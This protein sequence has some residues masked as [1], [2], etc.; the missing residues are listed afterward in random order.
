MDDGAQEELVPLG[1]GG[2]GCEEQVG[3]GPVVEVV[4]EV[5]GVVGAGAD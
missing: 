5:V 4:V 1:L 3:W 2:L